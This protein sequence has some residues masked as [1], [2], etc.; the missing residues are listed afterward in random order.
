MTA[1]FITA[2]TLAAGV[3]IVL[4]LAL[5]AAVK[6]PDK[7]VKK[8]GKKK[9]AEKQLF[10]PTFFTPFSTCPKCNTEGL[11]WLR[12]VTEDLIAQAEKIVPEYQSKLKHWKTVKEAWDSW[13]R[14]RND[15]YRYI[16]ATNRYDDYPTNPGKQP[17][18]P[19]NYD[20]LKSI[21]ETAFDVIRTCRECAHEWGQKT[22]VPE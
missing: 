9:A 17:G 13:Q 1:L 3:V 5:I 4:A 18:K 16:F 8:K 12:E 2:F 10:S 20:L 11:H 14:I 15:P 22:G 21:I 6:S 7:K 19:D